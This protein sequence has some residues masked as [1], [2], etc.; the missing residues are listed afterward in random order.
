MEN[1]VFTELVKRG[2]QPNR[3]IFYY[4]TKNNREIDF[5][6]KNGYKVM[7]LI[8]AAY[9]STE[10]AVEEREVKALIEAGKELEVE[11]LSVITWSEKREVEK[12]GLTI[13]FKPPW[14]W[15]LEATQK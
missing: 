15:L 7:E 13:Q 1:L 9:D 3:D 8:Q 11:K 10:S 12:D 2:K 14:E 4:T 5:V 6:L